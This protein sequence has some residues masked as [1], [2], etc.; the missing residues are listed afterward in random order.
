[1]I[2]EREPRLRGTRCVD[3]HVIA[4]TASRRCGRRKTFFSKLKFGK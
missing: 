3:A 2:D 4:T 1:M